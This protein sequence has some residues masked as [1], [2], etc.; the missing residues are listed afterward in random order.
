[1]VCKRYLFRW[2]ENKSVLGNSQERSN[3]SFDAGSWWPTLIDRYRK[4]PDCA[5]FSWRVQ[6]HLTIVQK[7]PACRSATY[8]I[9]PVLLHPVLVLPELPEGVVFHEQYAVPHA[10]ENAD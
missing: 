2:V 6:R 7:V 1:M 5:K 4:K 8:L 3:P 10:Q 9:I